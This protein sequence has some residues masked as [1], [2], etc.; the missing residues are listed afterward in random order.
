MEV[1]I[2]VRLLADEAKK[3]MAGGAAF[4]EIPAYLP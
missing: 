1:H 4:A 3:S 2:P